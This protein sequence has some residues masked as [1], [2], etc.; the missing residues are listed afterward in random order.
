M[1]SAALT[2]PSGVRPFTWDTASATVNGRPTS[3]AKLLVSAVQITNSK[4]FARAQ[5]MKGFSGVSWID[6]F[7]G[8]ET[9]DRPIF[10]MTVPSRARRSQIASSGLV[11]LL[12][13]QATSVGI[14]CSLSTTKVSAR[15]RLAETRENSIFIVGPS[16]CQG[17]CHLSNSGPPSQRSDP[18]PRIA[19][20]MLLSFLPWLA[21][22]L[23]V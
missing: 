12:T 8:G 3:V 15:R 10:S 13:H 14:P 17:P 11:R 22:L 7:D 18:H 21:A 2:L 20:L 23:I 4:F 19:I 5:A 1:Y 6:A 16:Y 9:A